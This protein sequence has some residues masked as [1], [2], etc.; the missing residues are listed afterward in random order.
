MNLVPSIAFALAGAGTMSVSPMVDPAPQPPTQDVALELRVAVQGRAP[1]LA[2]A[3]IT[4]LGYAGDELS[5]ELRAV[6]GAEVVDATGLAA[7]NGACSAAWYAGPCPD[8]Y[9]KARDAGRAH[10]EAVLASREIVLPLGHVSLVRMSDPRNSPVGA[11][12][13]AAAEGRLGRWRVQVA[14]HAYHAG[15]CD[16]EVRDGAWRRRRNSDWGGYAR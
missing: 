16:G 4:L 9:G 11:T 5:Y 1:I 13:R 10:G 8:C 12:R 6:V 7:V 15:C 3:E 14:R 2:P